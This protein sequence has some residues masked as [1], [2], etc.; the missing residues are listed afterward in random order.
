[1]PPTLVTVAVGV[2][3][4]LA[5]LGTAFDRR[6][7]F[8]VVG[9][10]AVPDLDAVASLYVPG[11]T[12]ALLHT[13]WIP[14]VAGCL[15]YWDTQRRDTSW[16]ADRYGWRG[17]RVAWVAVAVYAVAG[18]GLDLFS[19]DAVNLLYPVHDR[20]YSLV[21]RFT[22]STGDGLVQTYVEVG[23]RRLVAVTTQGTTADYHVASWVNPTPGTGNPPGVE[24]RVRLLASGWQAVVVAAAAVA[25][26]VTLGRDR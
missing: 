21:G 16:L 3:V 26:A 7:L 18:I 10:A 19:Q 4:G 24:R 8:A 23:G 11:V 1:M 15:L 5:L 9:V 20:F 22:I 25:T 14:L 6:S 2:L 17:V 12:N 13:G